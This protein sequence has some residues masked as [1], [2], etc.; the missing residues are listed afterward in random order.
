[1]KTKFSLLILIALLSSCGPSKEE[2][3]ASQM[4]KQDNAEIA[5]ISTP[6]QSERIRSKYFRSSKHS[7]YEII[8]VDGREFLVSSNG[9]LVPLFS[10]EGS[11]AGTP[12]TKRAY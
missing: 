12:F 2:R 8:E 9:G 11:S 1:M 10:T 6:S 4:A 7:W 3:A 5:K